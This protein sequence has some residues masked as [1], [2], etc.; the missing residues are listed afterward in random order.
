VSSAPVQA[1]GAPERMSPTRRFLYAIEHRRSIY[2]IAPETCVPDRKIIAV[3]EEA[4]KHVPSPFNVQSCRCVIL[5]KDEHQ[6]HW[7]MQ[8]AHFEAILPEA[9][10]GFVRGKIAESKKGYGSILFFDDQNAHKAMEVSMGAR[11]AGVAANYPSWTEHSQGMHHFAV[12]T[13]LSLAGFGCNLQH[14]VGNIDEKIQEE[15]NVPPEWKLRAQLVFG[16]QTGG[17]NKVKEFKNL[18]ESVKAYGL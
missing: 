13:A 17:P 6:K 18:S 16:K 14:Y 1:H 10:K 7:D 8:L 9:A 3:V 5:L 11:W 4:V 2:D 15:W 12:W